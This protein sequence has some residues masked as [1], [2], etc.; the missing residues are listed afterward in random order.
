MLISSLLLLSHFFPP[1]VS[2]LL[3]SSLQ[4]IWS[5]LCS[6]LSISLFSVSFAPPFPIL[7]LTSSDPHFSLPS[8]SPPLLLCHSISL[9]SASRCP[10]LHCVCKSHKFAVACE[11]E[12]DFGKSCVGLHGPGGWVGLPMT[13]VSST[14][15][16]AT[17]RHTSLV[18]YHFSW[19]NILM[20]FL[21]HWDS[22]RKL[23][24]SV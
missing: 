4:F 16:S 22:T 20:S 12:K 17:M 15:L 7:C 18:F 23:L 11:R 9:F 10:P 3:L 1:L 21:L 19:K 5:H 14:C 13:L 6:F 8:S 2:S 24:H